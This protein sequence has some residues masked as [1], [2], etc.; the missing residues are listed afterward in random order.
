M[1][2]TFEIYLEVVVDIDDIDEVTM[3]EL[4]QDQVEAIAPI[5]S[6]HVVDINAK[7]RTF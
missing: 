1:T 7:E 6:Y 5:R 4:V 2:R 3:E